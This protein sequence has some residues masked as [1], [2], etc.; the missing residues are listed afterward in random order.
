MQLTQK[1]CAHDDSV[2]GLLKTFVGMESD[3]SMEYN[4]IDEIS[5]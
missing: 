3:G 2:V 1:E 5:S 4:K